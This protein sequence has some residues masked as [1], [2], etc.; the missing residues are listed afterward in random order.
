MP[1]NA[2]FDV[3]IVAQEDGGLVFPEGCSDA[4]QTHHFA[5]VP[6]FFGELPQCGRFRTFSLINSAFG[7]SPPAFVGSACLLD[8]ENHA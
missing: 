4:G 1:F 3:D 6:S 2:T 7:K 5:H 8:E